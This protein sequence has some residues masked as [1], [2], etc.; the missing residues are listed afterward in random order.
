MLTVS[1]GG[2]TNST[3]ML[4]GLKNRGITPDAITFADTG[5]EKPHTLLHVSAMQEWC[6]AVGFPPITVVAYRS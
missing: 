4:V 3:A 1:Y 2:G 6:S 5:G